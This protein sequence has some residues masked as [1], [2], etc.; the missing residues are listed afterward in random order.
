MTK[1]RTKKVRRGGVR[2]GAGRP[3]L[4]EGAR[5]PLMVK[6]TERARQAVTDTAKEME[7]KHGPLATDGAAV[8]YLIRKAR[9]IPMKG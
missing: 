3:A 7:A 1:T 5:V 9:R 4:F 6:I 8:E 2:V